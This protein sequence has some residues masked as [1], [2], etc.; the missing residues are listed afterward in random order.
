[1]INNL[2]IIFDPLTTID[3]NLNW[4]SIFIIL[5]V[6]PKIFNKKYNRLTWI[7]YKISSFISENIKT[8]LKKINLFSL[9]NFE[10]Y[11]YAIF[12]LNFLRL[13]AYNFT[14][15]AHLSISLYFSLP[16]W[17]RII[18]KGY[19]SSFNKIITHLLPS[20]T[21]IILCCFI[22]L[23]ETT[24]IYIRPLTLSIRLAANIIAGHI[25]LYLLR[26]FLN[27]NLMLFLS[28]NNILIILLILEI[29]VSI[30]QR[31]VY[32]TLLSLYLDEIEI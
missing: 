13:Y 26:D 27:S 19:I 14:P 28:L 8:N 12:L 9:I 23:I 20:N 32:V 3:T 2:F 18:I 31:Y 6:I 1:M 24:R 25:L 17:I 7:F 10:R 5:A 4:I 11:F 29:S 15:R 30:I 22:I 16:F 21:P